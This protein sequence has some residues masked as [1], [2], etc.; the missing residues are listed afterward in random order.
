[1]IFP[2]VQDELEKTVKRLVDVCNDSRFERAEMYRKRES[3]F[4][5]GSDTRQPTRFNRTE[6]HIDLVSS[7]LYSPDHALF[8][9]AAESHAPDMVIRQ[10]IALEDSWNDDFQDAGLSD[11]FAEA[12]PWSLTYDSMI[13]KIGWNE[14]R[15]EIC[16]ELVPPHN[17]GVYREDIPD[18]DSQQAFCHTYFLDWHESVLRM[19]RAG[20]AGDIDKLQVTNRPFISPFPEMI[21]RM[22]VS[23]TGGSNLQGNV[24]G[25]VNP[26]YNAMATYQPRLS[27]VPTVEWNELWAWDDQCQDYRVFHLVQP[28]ILISDSLKYCDA[29]WGIESKRRRLS[30][31]AR[32]V[33]RRMR[34][35]ANSPFELFP[36]DMR[37]LP[38]NGADEGYHRS[39]CN[40]F[41]PRDHPFTVIKPFGK[42]NYFWGIAHID[43][44]FALQDWM[45]ERMEQI[46]DIL[47]KQAYPPRVGSGMMGLTDEKM[48]A[49]GGADTWVYD[50]VPNAKIEELRPEMPPDLFAELNEIGQLFM[51]A[52]GLTELIVGRGETG[53]RSGRQGRQQKQTGGSRIKKAALRLETSLT[54]IGD[55]GLRLK[56]RNDTDT[57]HPEPSEGGQESVPFL[58]AQIA[59]DIKLRVDGHSHSPLFADES[60][61]MA[62]LLK[63]VGAVDNEMFIRMINPP[64]KY[65]ILHALRENAKKQARMLQQHPELLDKMVGAHKGARK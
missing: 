37:E 34:P 22:I 56:M 59:G 51:E 31:P 2:R 48:M 17:F 24:T 52:S 9:I 27:D 46:S 42:F 32:L 3:Y 13:F 7:F 21:N 39:R 18:L 26:L 58:P 15:D 54:R 6:A 64:A 60:R 5:F 50:Q 4:L 40:M 65:N 41:L 10:A 47:E 20:R 1:M 29:L 44:L 62:V 57:L 53:V 19:V 25:Q 16:A 45:T 63:R 43:K 30:V 12:I 55:L 38:T 23:A 8:H 14:T 11:L 33:G 36:D 49:F 61:E 35:G 28:D